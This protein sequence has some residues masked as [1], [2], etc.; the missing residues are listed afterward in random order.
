MCSTHSP[1]GGAAEEESPKA[2]PAVGG[3]D[4]Q[5]ASTFAREGGDLEVGLA[6]K[7]SGFDRYVGLTGGLPEL[8]EGCEAAAIHSL[9]DFDNGG[10]AVDGRQGLRVDD[11]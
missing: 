4:D 2:R 5:I 3:Q 6:G 8:S 7:D 9:R 11:V 1:L 10:R